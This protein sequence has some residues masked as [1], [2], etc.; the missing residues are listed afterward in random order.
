MP[1]VPHHESLI[2]HLITAPLLIFSVTKLS[3]SE[4]VSVLL[5]SDS[6]NFVQVL[7]EHRC[8]LQYYISCYF[9]K[10]IVVLVYEMKM[11]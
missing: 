6:Q 11:K 7:G 1:F 10:Q 3:Y 4:P 8:Q 2:H 9:K 5:V